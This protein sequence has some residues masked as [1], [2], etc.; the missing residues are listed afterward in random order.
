M[1][2]QLPANKQILALPPEQNAPIEAA[3][4]QLREQANHKIKRHESRQEVDQQAVSH[5]RLVST[6][7]KYVARAIKRQNE[8]REKS[9][10][11]QCLISDIGINIDA[12]EKFH[13]RLIGTKGFNAPPC[14]ES[15]CL[16]QALDITLAPWVCSGDYIV[17]DFTLRR[18]TIDG[19]YLVTVYGGYIALCGFHR[20]RDGWY[21]HESAGGEPRIVELIDDRL[22]KEFEILGLIKR[23]YKSDSANE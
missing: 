22:P 7:A 17:V 18:L 15:S 14:G 12:R 3:M 5:W 16:L 21:V 10:L 23:A 4:R 13:G 6:Y 19:I 11:T 1:L 2:L 9:E 8:V 20:T